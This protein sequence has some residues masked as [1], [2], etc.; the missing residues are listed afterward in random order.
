[1]FWIIMKGYY[2]LGFYHFEF[3][4]LINEVKPKILL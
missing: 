1:M 2:M 4:N 3:K